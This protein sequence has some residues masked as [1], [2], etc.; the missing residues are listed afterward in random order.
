[1]NR[2]AGDGAG[3]RRAIAAKARFEI[4][5]RDAFTCLYCGRKPP[6]VTLEVD[7]VI[8]VANGGTN[9]SENL[10]TACSECNGGK[11]AVPL[12]AIPP[13]LKAQRRVAEERRRQADAYSAWLKERFDA[14]EAE[15]DEIDRLYSSKLL[16]GGY[17]LSDSAR[18][19]VRQF[20]DFLPKQKLIEAVYLTAGRAPRDPF[21]YMCSIC[22]NW[23]RGERR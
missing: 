14:R 23:I 13:P 18:A 8:A 3:K 6:A 1:M 9:T 5:K 11:S 20:L 4:F 2:A 12:N 19:S 21:R 7:H 17:A 22:W 16:R 10:A 15:V